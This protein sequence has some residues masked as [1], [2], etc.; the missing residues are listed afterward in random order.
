MAGERV[1]RRLVVVSS[2][3]RRI[4]CNHSRFRGRPPNLTDGFHLDTDRKSAIASDSAIDQGDLKPSS[5][6][7]EVGATISVRPLRSGG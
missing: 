5:F 4:S 3:R 2:Q 6:L 7:I 1:R